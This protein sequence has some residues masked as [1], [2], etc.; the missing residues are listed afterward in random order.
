MT[1]LWWLL[2]FVV[3][4]RL[5]E[6]AYAARNTRR[7]RAAGGIEH[8]RRHY[9]LIV[10]LHVAWLASIAALVPP[11]TPPHAGMLAAFAA[12][13]V[14]RVW[15]I[16]TLGSRWTTRIITVPGAPLVHRGPYRYLRHPNYL[17]V[18]CEIAVFPLIFGAW[19][20]ALGFSVANAAL[21]AWRIRVENAALV[22]CRLPS[23]RC[24]PEAARAPR[25]AANPPRETAGPSA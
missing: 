18:A 25:G 10:A 20:I 12:L 21:L 7:L 4:Q 1:P 23:P 2:G 6:L 19:Q 11:A 5:A 13:Q 9:P 14:A 15:I 17:L 24:E 16:A 3:V 8:G 22:S